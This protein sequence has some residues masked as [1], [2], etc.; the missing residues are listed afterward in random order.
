MI[1]LK[2]AAR[3]ITEIL[4]AKRQEYKLTFEEEGHV[5]TMLDLNGNLRSDWESVSTVEK[6]FYDEFD[7]K[8]KALDMCWG[9]QNGQK[10]LLEKW[11][12]GSEYATNKGSRAHYELEKY[13]VQKFKLNKSVRKPIFECDEQQIS[14]SNKMIKAGKEFLNLMES[15]GCT[16]IDTEVTLGSNTLGFTGQGDDLWITLAKDKNSIGVIWTDHKTNSVKNLEPQRYNGYLKHPFEEYRDYAIS[17]YYIQLS[18][19]SK[20]LLDMLKGSK[21]ENIP[22]LGCILDSLRDNGTFEEY[23]VPKTFIDT[24]LTIDLNKYK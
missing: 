12:K 24:I 14:D 1:D 23:R 9:D 8:Q 22:I 20:L 4:E 11:K 21:Y 15:R 6:I 19:Y 17:H 13:A 18:L 5:Y 7:D 2:I 10:I 3:E 16:L